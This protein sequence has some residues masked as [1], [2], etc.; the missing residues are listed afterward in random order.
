MQASGNGTPHRCTGNLLK[1]IRGEVPY[2]RL[3]GIDPTLF[4]QPSR[5]AAPLLQADVEWVLRTYEPRADLTG[6][7][8][9]ALA[10]Q[11]GDFM[12]NVDINGR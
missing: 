3:R 7:A 6:S 12:L 5:Q 11:F 8:L 2:D 4:D 9:T 1:T 10:A